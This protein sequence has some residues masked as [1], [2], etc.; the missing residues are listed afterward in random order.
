MAFLDAE[1]LELP[2]RIILSIEGLRGTGKTEFGLWGPAPVGYFRF[3]MASEGAIRKMRAKR[4]GCIKVCTYDFERPMS[5]KEGMTVR[6]FDKDL[7]DTAV[8]IYN[9]FAADYRYAH[10]NGMKSLVVD[11]LGTLWELFRI[12]R[13]GKVE[14]VP[15]ERYGLL[16]FELKRLLKESLEAG[17]MLTCIS[18]L[19][20]QWVDSEDA[21]GKRKSYNTGKYI[22]D[23]FKKIE[24]LAGA[25][26]RLYRVGDATDPYK[27]AATTETMNQFCAQ[28]LKANE[29]GNLVGET[30][31]FADWASADEENTFGIIMSMLFS[32]TQPGDWL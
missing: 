24:Y 8:E 4:P 14:Q 9:S 27:D 22:L 11:D 7:I 17:V 23:S 30:V 6:A 15:P 10:K 1:R 29:A 19:K 3:D 16:N 26:V 20:E 31:N 18:P 13:F 28:F 12:A 21:A 5:V 25:M 2:K 32:D